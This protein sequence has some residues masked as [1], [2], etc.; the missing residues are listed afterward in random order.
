MSRPIGGTIQEQ[1]EWVIGEAFAETS[2]DI[3]TD[4][5]LGNEIEWW[6]AVE[7]QDAVRNEA[8]RQ[9]AVRKQNDEECDIDAVAMDV[10]GWVSSDL[11]SLGEADLHASLK[12]YLNDNDMSHKHIDAICTRVGEHVY[13]AI[14]PYRQRY[15]NA[16]R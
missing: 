15:L 8:K 14:Q 12:E 16:R 5:E 9:L 6:V 7:S 1:A 2:H 11:E 13:A 10:L 3:P 4:E